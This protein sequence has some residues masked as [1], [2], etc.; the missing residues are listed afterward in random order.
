MDTAQRAIKQHVQRTHMR[1]QHATTSRASSV[2][3]PAWTHTTSKTPCSMRNDDCAAHEHELLEGVA[4]AS[5]C[6]NVHAAERRSAPLLTVPAPPTSAGAN[7]A[8]SRR[9]KTNGG[10]DEVGAAVH[11]QPVDQ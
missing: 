2:E 3:H 8:V 7:S 11:V 5:I 6:A 9:L 10:A 1:T 4:A